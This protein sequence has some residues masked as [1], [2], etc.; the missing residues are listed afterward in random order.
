MIFVVHQQEP[1]KLHMQEFISCQQVHDVA[2]INE[3]NV[4]HSE[5][6]FLKT[7]TNLKFVRD[8][9]C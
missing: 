4:V 5:V 6:A 9:L 2:D 1:Q 3:G 7:S 8:G